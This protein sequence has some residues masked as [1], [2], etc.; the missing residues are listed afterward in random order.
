TAFGGG[1]TH[2]LLSVYHLAEGK[3]PT[4]KLQGINKILTDAGIV[5]LPKA[6]VA[7]LDGVELLDLASKPRVHSSTKVKTLWGELAWQLGGAEAVA[8][9]KEADADGT[10]PG[11]G[12]L[13]EILSDAAPCI[14]LMDELVRYVSQF[15]EGKVLSGGTYDTQISFIQSLTEA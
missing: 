3:K 8:K 11:K 12:V 5:E 7:V 13:A 9:I 2:T 15:E 1:K 10:A 4:I 14:V 6:K